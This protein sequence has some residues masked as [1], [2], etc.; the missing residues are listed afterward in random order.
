[1]AQG[2]GGPSGLS[3][4][5]AQAWNSVA[6]A[7]ASAF[8]AAGI[9]Q[10]ANA[11]IAV[12]LGMAGV[13]NPLW[14]EQFVGADPG[15]GALRLEND[16]YTTLVGA[17]G[18]KPGTIVAIGTGSVGQALLADGSLR[19]VG[20]WG[21][22]TGDEAGGGWMGLR[23]IAHI[24]KVID[25]RAPHSAFAQAVIDACG[26]ERNAIQVW[27]G[28][29]T[30]T[31]FASLAPLVVAHAATCD[32]ARAILADAGREV[33]LMAHALD[34]SGQLPLALCGGLGAPLRAYLPPDLLA[35]SVAPLGDSASGALRMI[36]LHVRGH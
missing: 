10:P 3:L 32:T 27:I 31:V 21:F 23:A 35:R 17:H 24:E 20:G 28:G 16:G 9:A 2:Q 13:H 1:L 4:G 12:G 8:G 36:E 33:A 29:A 15:F 19:E 34:P 14:A 25:G 30:Q 7:L 6:D 5:I 26:G 18:G 22:P 11:N